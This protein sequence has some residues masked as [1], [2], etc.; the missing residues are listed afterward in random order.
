VTRETAIDMWISFRNGFRDG[1]MRCVP[2]MIF[3]DYN[4]CDKYIKHIGTIC[5]ERAKIGKE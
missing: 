1:F 2:L 3:L 5:F 4:N